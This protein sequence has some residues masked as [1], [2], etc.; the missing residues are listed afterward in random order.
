ME[1]KVTNNEPIVHIL[2]TTWLNWPKRTGQQFIHYRGKTW[3]GEVQVDLDVDDVGGHRI[4]VWR[5][6]A[7]YTIWSKL[8]PEHEFRFMPIKW[9]NPPSS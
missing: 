8:Q 1:E 4:T 7:Y 5:G 3:V 9:P 6:N 2:I